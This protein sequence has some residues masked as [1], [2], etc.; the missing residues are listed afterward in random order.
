MQEIRKHTVND[1][2]KKTYTDLY[3]VC[4]RVPYLKLVGIF[5]FLL[6]EPFESALTGSAVVLCWLWK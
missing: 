4:K 6:D 5:Y 2:L 1:Q 3:S